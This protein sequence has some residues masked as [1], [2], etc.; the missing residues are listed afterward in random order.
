MSRKL[1]DIREDAR[2]TLAALREWVASDPRDGWEKTYLL[3]LI[4][5]A[6]SSDDPRVWLGEPTKRGTKPT[7]ELYQ[8]VIAIK[9]LK[10]MSK[11]NPDTG[12]RYTLEQASL[13]LA[14]STGLS[15]SYVQDIHSEFKERKKIRDERDQKARGKRATNS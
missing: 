4:D 15:S 1:P 3:S 14:E 12:K 10:F 6:Y 5:E 7:S 2:E 9:V 11:N 13:I 8:A